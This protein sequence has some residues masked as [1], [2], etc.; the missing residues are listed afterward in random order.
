MKAIIR[1]PTTTNSIDTFQTNLYPW[2]LECSGRSS[3]SAETIG[4]G[5]SGAALVKAAT[6]VTC[7]EVEVDALSPAAPLTVF[8][9]L[10]TPATVPLIREDIDTGV[11][12][13]I[14]PGAATKPANERIVLATC[15]FAP[16][17]RKKTVRYGIRT[18]S[19]VSIVPAINVATTKR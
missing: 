2:L 4:A 6:T 3:V 11:L 7:T 5:I 19:A 9:L 16:N 15:I 10:S 12:A 1:I 14:R 17:F 18:T 8:A 13:A